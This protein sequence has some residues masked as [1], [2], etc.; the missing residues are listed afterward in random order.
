MST[1]NGYNPPGEDPYDAFLRQEWAEEA[2]ER[3]YREEQAR[4]ERSEDSHEGRL[5]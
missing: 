2:A 1:N 5:D 3:R 4:L